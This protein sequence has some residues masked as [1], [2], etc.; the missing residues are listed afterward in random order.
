MMLSGRCA[1][2]PRVGNPFPS[3]HLAGAQH[4]I[5]ALVLSRLARMRRRRD[6][7][8]CA[9]AVGPRAGLQPLKSEHWSHLRGDAAHSAV[10]DGPRAGLQPLKW[11][12]GDDRPA[13]AGLS[14]G[15]PV[16]GATVGKSPTLAMEFPVAI[17]VLPQF[18]ASAPTTSS[19]SSAPALDAHA[20]S[21]AKAGRSSPGSHF[22]GCRPARGPSATAEWAASRR[23]LG[24]VSAAS[25]PRQPRQNKRFDDV[26]RAREM[27]RRERVSN[28]RTLGAATP[29]SSSS[30]PKVDKRAPLRAGTSL[31]QRRPRDFVRSSRG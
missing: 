11:E 1:Q 12:P 31:E 25:H 30:R 2:R 26:L 20:D 22:S 16:A 17:S 9:V 21:P 4:I 13:F 15:S 27:C 14:A 28:P 8:H 23:R 10:A 24:G 6:A 7:A 29:P 5:E 18:S 3:T 19:S